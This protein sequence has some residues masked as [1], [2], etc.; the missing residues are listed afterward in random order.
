[1]M[2]GDRKTKIVVLDDEPTTSRITAKV[3]R[4]EL[5][6]SVEVLTATGAAQARHLIGE[7]QCDILVSDIEMP[8][9]DGLDVLR[10]TRRCNAWT[11]VIMITGHSTWDRLSEAIEGGACDYL[12]KPL[13]RTQLAQIVLQEHER[14]V[15]WK[16]A[17]RG[18]RVIEHKVTE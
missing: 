5:A 6:D 12:L 15:R 3:L 17:I 16:Q 9:A 10:F 14:L 7:N 1:M 13:D 2:L 11:R 8:D 18:N 4:E